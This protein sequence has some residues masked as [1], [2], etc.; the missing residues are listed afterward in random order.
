MVIRNG[1]MASFTY[2]AHMVFQILGSVVGIVVLWFLWSAI[3][4]AAGTTTVRGMS[5]GQTFL[6]VGLATALFVMMRTWIEW[7]MNAQI[8]TGDIVVHFFRPYSYTGWSLASSLG[9]VAGNLITI[10]V[11][12]LV[13]IFLIFHAPLPPWINVVLFIPAL[14]QAYLLSFLIDFA[15]GVTAFHT[16]SIWGVSAS[17]ESVVLFLSGG[18]VPLAFFPDPMRSVLLVLPFAS[19]FNTPIALL[20]GGITDLGQ[21]AGRLALQTFWVVVF[22]LAV[23]W[24]YRASVKRLTVAG[25]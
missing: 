2:R 23:R 25:G 17:K 8:R 11:P 21:I 3:Y 10:T 18:L 13:T 4:A 7:D 9:F 14:V 19:M 15:V 1:L 22:W 16:E 12:S 5:F 24:Y 20:A 6:Y